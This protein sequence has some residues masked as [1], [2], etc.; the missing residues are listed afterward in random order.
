MFIIFILESEEIEHTPIHEDRPN[1]NVKLL[2]YKNKSDR[3]HK[4]NDTKS[5]SISPCLRI[6]GGHEYY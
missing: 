3:D 1:N 6:Y 2:I 4:F 5:I